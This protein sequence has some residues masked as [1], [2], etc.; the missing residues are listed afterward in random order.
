[1]DQPIAIM[2]PGSETSVAGGFGAFTTPLAIP[3]FVV[4]LPNTEGGE[5]FAPQLLRLTFMRPEA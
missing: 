4:H 1:V 3:R 5:R 2:T